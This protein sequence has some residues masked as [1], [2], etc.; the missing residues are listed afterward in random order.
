V[1]PERKNPEGACDV[2]DLDLVIEMTAAAREAAGWLAGHP[3]GRGAGQ[4]DSWPEFKAAFD[5]ADEPVSAILRDRLGS[6]RPGTPWTDELAPEVTGAGETWVVD[7][8]DGAVQYLQGLPQWTVS[9]AL[10]RDGRP[11]L[12]VLHSALLR[13]TYTAASGGGARRNGALIRPSGKTRLG[14]ALVATSQPPLAGNQ[15]AAVAAAGRALTA[16]LPAVG[17]VR[18]LGPTS[19]QVADVASGRIDAFY[20]YGRDASNLV[21]GSLLASESGVLVT[22]AGGRPWSPS[23]A[24][25]LAAPAALHAQLVALLGRD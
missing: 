10:V 16:L 17:A 14:L 2:D 25:F 12:A 11:V 15:P 24:S 19:W 8:I 9:V 21:A 22:D 23:S 3:A 5:A 1:V 18:N 13:E 7:A 6:A 20:E 4:F